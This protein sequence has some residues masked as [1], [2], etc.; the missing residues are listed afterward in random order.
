MP[1]LSS[2]A[3]FMSA[4]NVKTGDVVEFKDG[5][6]YRESKFFYPDQTQ[7]GKPHPKAGQQKKD[8]VFNVSVGDKEMVFTCNNT[9]QA[10]LKEAWGC[11]TDKWASRKAS[12]MIVKVSV[13]GK[14]KDSVLLTP[15]A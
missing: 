2:G 3:E 4:K 13:G 15:V 8:L 11:D 5:G 12:I 1:M 10:V 6:Q 14:I 9:N 7:D